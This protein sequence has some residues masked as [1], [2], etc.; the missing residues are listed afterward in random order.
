[1][2]WVAWVVAPAGAVAADKPTF[3]FPFGRL[4]DDDGRVNRDAVAWPGDGHGVIDQFSPGPMNAID[5]KRYSDTRV[6]RLVAFE[7]GVTE[8]AVGGDIAAKRGNVLDVRSVSIASLSPKVNHW[9]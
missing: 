3:R 5:G 6:V 2:R 9:R 7:V 1:M 4:F 8:N